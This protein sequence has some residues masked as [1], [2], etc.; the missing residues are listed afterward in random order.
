MYHCGK[1]K[2]YNCINYSAINK[3]IYIHS[4][5]R[6]WIYITSYMDLHKAFYCT[7]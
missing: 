5:A 7:E 1:Q 6:K 4:H 3:P 2:Q